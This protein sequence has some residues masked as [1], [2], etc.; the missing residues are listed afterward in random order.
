MVCA[1][2]MDKSSIKFYLILNA[3]ASCSDYP[4]QFL[5]SLIKQATDET[6]C[7]LSKCSL[8]S[9]RELVEPT[10][11]TTQPQQRATPW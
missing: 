8:L 2:S 10:Q 4:V 9:L 5:R 1:C 11:P 3:I 6:I 7:P